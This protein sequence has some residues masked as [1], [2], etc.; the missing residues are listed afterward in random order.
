M[1][2]SSN[3]TEKDRILKELEH[4]EKTRKSGLISEKEY[5]DAKHSIEKK[6]ADTEKKAKQK[7]AKD[8]AVKNIIGLP[9]EEVSKGSKKYFI[10]IKKSKEVEK[11]KIPLKNKAVKK[12][13]PYKKSTKVNVSVKKAT[14][15]QVKK[16]EAPVE[17]SIAET[18]V[19]KKPIFKDVED[20]INKE[21]I[22]E[23]EPEKT[24]PIPS[25]SIQYKD[26]DDIVE[27]QETNW[28]LGLAVLTIF[29][30][31]LLYIK[32]TSFGAVAGVVAV[33][34][35]LDYDSSYSHDMNVIL[36]DLELE[37]GEGIWITYHIIG[38]G[39]KNNLISIGM[40]CADDQEK[41][42]AYLEYAFVQE[43]LVNTDDLVNYAEE[44]GLDTSMFRLCV[45][46][47][48]KSMLNNREIS[49]AEELGIDHTP[50]LVINNKKI[51]GAVGYDA[52]KGLIDEELNSL[53]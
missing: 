45:E 12:K 7:V 6:Q 5:K 31:I 52:V 11:E 39:E 27:E 19:S 36:Q 42:S 21:P 17:K 48:V 24:V 9:L 3:K 32:F 46:S 23:H 47:G 16:I 15:K 34:A 22:V 18:P 28:R 1:V 38:S 43:S 50:T 33:D 41:G 8:N 49:A 44:L 40:G 51:V 37:Y 35:Y 4:L 14:K 2:E 20:V 30:L 10:K 26:I 53:G 13:S 25:D 29:L